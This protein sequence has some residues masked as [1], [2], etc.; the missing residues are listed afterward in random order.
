MSSVLS[1]DNFEG[2]YLVVTFGV[3]E[4]NGF[5]IVDVYARVSV[6][7]FSKRLTYGAGMT[8]P[9]KMKIE[10]E[11]AKAEVSSVVRNRHSTMLILENQ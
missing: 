3:D 6:H 10:I 7:Q 2:L 9:E 5:V 4:R 1:F 11:Q 8:S